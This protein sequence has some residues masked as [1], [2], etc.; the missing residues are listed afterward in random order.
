MHFVSQSDLPFVGMSHE[1]VGADQGRVGISVYLVHSPPGRATRLHRHPYDEVAFVREGHGRWTVD[2]VEREA[3][4]DDIL[5]VKAGEIHK[6]E[7]IGDGPLVQLDV[8]LN[9]RFVQENLD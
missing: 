5:V 6:F 8:H 2:G 1:F 9:E 3:G 4:P 7:N